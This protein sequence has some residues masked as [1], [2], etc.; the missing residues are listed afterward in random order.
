VI[1]THYV[2][3]TVY[4]HSVNALLLAISSDQELGKTI[5][6]ITDGRFSGASTGP[7]IGHC[8]PEAA[9]GGP[10]ALVEEGDL[11]ELDVNERRLD[12]VGVAGERKTPEEIEEILKK[13][14]E[15]WKTRSR[16]YERGTLRMFSEHAVSPMRGAWL[17]YE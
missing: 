4:N 13:R 5:A 7:V 14:R 16:K 2:I 11:I 17:D 10:I 12:I 3:L 8:S 9:T 15:R 6:L 1:K